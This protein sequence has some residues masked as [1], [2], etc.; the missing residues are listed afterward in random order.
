MVAEKG[1]GAKVLDAL[2]SYE[3]IKIVTIKNKKVGF[4]HRIIQL[5]ILGY[6]IGFVSKFYY[7]CLHK[8]C[9]LSFEFHVHIR[10]SLNYI[11][12]KQ[13]NQF[14]SFKFLYHLSL[15]MSLLENAGNVA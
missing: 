3:T 4:L 1:F 11:F 13:L 15:K 10:P 6:V 12:T 9:L 2:L 8:C 14:L 5:A 7:I